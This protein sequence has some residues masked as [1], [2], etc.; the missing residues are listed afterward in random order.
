MKICDLCKEKTSKLITLKDWIQNVTDA[1]EV[2][3]SCEEV[4][5][6]HINKAIEEAEQMRIKVKEVA[7]TEAIKEI[8][9]E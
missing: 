8:R 3:P 5:N 7:I 6:T 4:F 1:K 9:G 2:C